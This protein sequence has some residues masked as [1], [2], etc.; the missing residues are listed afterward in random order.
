MKHH[1]IAKNPELTSKALE[2]I[3]KHGRGAFDRVINDLLDKKSCPIKQGWIKR[4][5]KQL[6]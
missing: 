1:Y 5:R 3:Y 6:H 4:N 2:Y